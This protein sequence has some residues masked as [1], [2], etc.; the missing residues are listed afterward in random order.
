VRGDADAL[1]DAYEATDLDLEAGLLVQLAP[2]RG[3][4]GLAGFHAPARQRQ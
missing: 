4:Q 3:R 2:H 1:G